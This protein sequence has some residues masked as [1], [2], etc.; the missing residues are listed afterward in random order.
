MPDFLGTPQQL[1]YTGNEQAFNPFLSGT[2]SLI[3]TG[4]Q[5]TLAPNWAGYDLGAV[6]LDRLSWDDKLV[7]SNGQVGSNFQRKYQANVEETE[8]ALNAQAEAIIAI[9]QAL[10]EAAKANAAA[11]TAQDTANAQ[12]IETNLVNSYTDPLNV[13]TASS[14]GEVVIASHNRV[15]GDGT[16]VAVTGGTVTGYASG[17]TVRP[18]YSD[19]EQLGGAVVWQSTTGVVSQTNGTHLVGGARIPVAG[20]PPASGGGTVPP[21]YSIDEDIP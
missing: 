11:Q 13:L 6:E 1:V 14:D 9:Q 8:K 12:A 2:A 5:S 7:G 16:T 15:Y 4:L 10:D 18:Y 21:G 19:T 20:E 3:Y 17:E